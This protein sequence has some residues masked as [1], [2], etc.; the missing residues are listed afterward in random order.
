MRVQDYGIQKVSFPMNKTN[1]LKLVIVCIAVCCGGF[2]GYAQEKIDLKEKVKLDVYANVYLSGNTAIGSMFEELVVG[3]HVSDNSFLG[4]GFMHSGVK[5]VFYGGI[6]NYSYMKAWSTSLQ[7]VPSM[8][9]GFLHGPFSGTEVRTK[10]IVDLGVELR[11][12]L[13]RK[14]TSFCGI[15]T[16]VLCIEGV[17][18]NLWCGLTFGM[19]F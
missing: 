10:F 1:V 8:E 11:Q 7:L 19:S 16:K 13:G 5:T 9:A 6:V 4:A 15:G 17:D 12:W 3:Y 2:S 14:Q 18:V